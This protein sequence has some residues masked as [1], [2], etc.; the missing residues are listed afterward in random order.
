MF[1][2]G[3]KYLF[4]VAGAALVG[5][6][7]FGLIT[8]GSIL[9][10]ISIGYKGGVGVHT[11]YA[12]LLAVAA[13]SLALGV[14]NVIV[15]DGEADVVTAEDGGALAIATPR[16]ASYWGPIAA[17][18]LACLA[19]GVAVSQAFF[20]LGLVILA[21]VLLEWVVLAWSDRATGD[22]E[23][24]AAIRDRI[25][26]PIE[27]PLLAVLTIAVVVLGVSRVLLAVSETGSVVVAAGV[28]AAIFL[29][30]IGIAKSKAPRAV[31]TGIVAV[32][33]LAVLA[34]GIVGAAV[35]E[36]HIGETE[37]PAGEGAGE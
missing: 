12:I 29:C 35:G 36:R 15:R 21:V 28:A 27:V 1:T 22:H 31:I 34:G 30:A 25:I 16:T 9:G 8:G 5:A 33:A 7:L 20:I 24:N 14:L 17:F 23:V 6:L 4:G 2:W 18:G 10:V 13:A 32:A 19:V 11:G 3:S 26:G 37:T